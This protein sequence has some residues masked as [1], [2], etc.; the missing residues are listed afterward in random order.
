MDEPGR[1]ESGA[2]E[3][4]ADESAESHDHGSL[5]EEAARLAEAVQDWLRTSTAGG[6]LGGAFAGASRASAAR[7]VWAAATQPSSDGAE[8]NVCPVCALLRLVRHARPEVFEHLSDAAAS[9]TAALR[10]LAGEAGRRAEGTG[11]GGRRADGGGRSGVEHIDL[12]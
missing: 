9:F 10:D 2:H 12:G 5:G 6:G 1:H 4:G 7:D 11:S 3:P 8:C